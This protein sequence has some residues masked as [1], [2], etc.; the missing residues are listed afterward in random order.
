M[1]WNRCEILYTLTD[2]ILAS[3]GAI[4]VTTPWSNVF[5]KK[6]IVAQIVK[7]SPPFTKTESLLP[8]SQE[9]TTGSYPEPDE[10]SQHPHTLFRQGPL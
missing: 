3:T 4:F 8:C 5:L 1:D 10:S 7:K 2:T 9:A 6:L